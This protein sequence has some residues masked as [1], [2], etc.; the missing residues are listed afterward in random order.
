[1]TI[2]LNQASELLMSIALFAASL[3]IVRYTRRRIRELPEED[4]RLGRPLYGYAVGTWIMGMASLANYLTAVFMDPVTLLF[5]VVLAV[6]APSMISMAAL[7]V[8]GRGQFILPLLF[9]IVL[10]GAV[11]VAPFIASRDAVLTIAGSVS[12][13]LYVPAFL[14]FGY[15]LFRTTR[16]TSFALF[17][18][19]ASYPWYPLTLVPL[20]PSPVDLLSIVVG[21]RLMGPAFAVVAFQM[22]DIGISIELTVYGMAY[23]LISFWFSYVMIS[24]VDPVLVASLTMIALGSTIGFGTGAYTYARWKKSRLGATFALFLSFTFTTWAFILVALKG[25]GLA[26]QDFYAYVIIILTFIGLMT[27]NMAAFL[28]LE[29]RSLTLLPVLM[30]IPLFLFLTLQ[31]PAS[32]TGSPLF[33]LIVTVTG[34]VA[35]VVPVGVYLYLWQRMRHASAPSASRPLLLAMG[36]L[37]FTVAM[38]VGPALFH[39]VVLDVANP[40]SG[41]LI[42][43]GFLAWWLAVTGRTEGFTKWWYST[44]VKPKSTGTSVS[45]AEVASPPGGA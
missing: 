36:I 37:E 2:L 12:G 30:M 16:A 21:L 6:L 41:I 27:F 45:R 4:K 9:S 40:I 22:R 1:V 31:Y 28:G 43:A 44:T 24:G 26:T 32:P 42:L 10:F 17:Y 33:T 19:V 7:F 5:Y 18:L 14:L 35:A 23:A 13:I 38:A 15:I 34:L 20:P 39:A 29:W 3:V 25:I 8:L 11:I